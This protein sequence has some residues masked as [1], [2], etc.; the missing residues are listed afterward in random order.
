MPV[1]IY[2]GEQV[3]RYVFVTCLFHSAV[4]DS[5]DQRRKDEKGKIFELFSLLF[6]CL[7]ILIPYLL[8]KCHDIINLED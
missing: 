7:Q 2:H 3:T 1:T 4:E 5:A 8:I 6:K